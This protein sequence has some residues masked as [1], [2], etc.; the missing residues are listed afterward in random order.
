MIL[1]LENKN[2][3]S[4]KQS[5]EDKVNKFCQTESEE[6]IF[7]YEC[8]FPAEDFYDFGEHMLE[9]HFDGICKGCAETFTT[10]EKLSD[11]ISISDDHPHEENRSVLSSD[12][13]K[14]NHC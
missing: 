14:C 9:Y 5:L 1:S 10:K 12:H 2:T 8:E 3:S 6:M 4:A 11:H 13:F 7:C